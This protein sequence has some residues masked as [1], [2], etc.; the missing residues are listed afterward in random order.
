MRCRCPRAP[1]FWPI[2]SLPPQRPP[3]LGFPLRPPT[4]APAAGLPA[5]V[6][7]YRVEPSSTTV[8]RASR[9]IRSGTAGAGRSPVPVTHK[10]LTVLRTLR[11][12]AKLLGLPNGRARFSIVTRTAGAEH[13]NNA[14]GIVGEGRT[15]PEVPLYQQQLSGECKRTPCRCVCVYMDTCICVRMVL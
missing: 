3:K 8:P 14:L 5:T 6:F 11:L 10:H 4:A 9:A 15:L 7:F 12:W 13:R 2:L 1:G